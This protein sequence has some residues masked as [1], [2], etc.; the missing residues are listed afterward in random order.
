MN[1]VHNEN[2]YA[3]RF[4]FGIDLSQTLLKTPF[5]VLFFQKVRAITR[6]TWNLLYDFSN[7]IA[8]DFSNYDAE[9][10]W[11]VLIDEFVEYAKAELVNS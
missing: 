10:A 11:P 2:D 3:F 9:G 5:R 7:T 4:V 1:L 6:D 8:P